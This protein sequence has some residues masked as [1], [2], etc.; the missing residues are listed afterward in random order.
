MVLLVFDVKLWLRFRGAR[1]KLDRNVKGRTVRMIVEHCN[2]W[3]QA[4][5]ATEMMPAAEP[6][7]P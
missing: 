5:V 2:R 3:L 7:D 4:L 6:D 1:W